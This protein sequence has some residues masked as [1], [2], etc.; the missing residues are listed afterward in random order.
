[1]SKIND[2][3]YYKLGHLPA[4]PECYI[5]EGLTA[6]FNYNPIPALYWTPPSTFESTDFVKS[7]REKFG[8]SWVKF[9]L[10]PS[11]VLY[12]WHSD[13]SR[14][15]SI[16]WVIKTNPMAHTFFKEPVKETIPL[17]GMTTLTNHL[18]EVEY[19]LYKPTI[20][21]T[22]KKHCVI[23]NYPEDRIIMSMSI[24]NEASYEEV[25]EYLKNL[26]ITTY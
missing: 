12:D 2:Q 23:N 20:L 26:S 11:N 18:I 16:N 17:E 10:F 14:R 24:F 3:Y 22:T 6:T 19:D 8:F 13:S 7:L 1:M 5:A 15:C 21:N 4:L 9:N 25:L